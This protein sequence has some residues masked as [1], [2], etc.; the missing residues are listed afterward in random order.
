MEPRNPYAK[1]LQYQSSPST[2]KTTYGSSYQDLPTW[3]CSPTYER[4]REK[5]IPVHQIAHFPYDR[6]PYPMAR[7]FYPLMNK[8]PYQ[9][10]PFDDMQNQQRA[11]ARDERSRFE[12]A[13]LKRDMYKEPLPANRH[14]GK[15]DELERYEMPR[16][17][18]EHARHDEPR[19]EDQMEYRKSQYDDLV[20]EGHEHDDEDQK[21]ALCNK[22]FRKGVCM[23]R[24][25]CQHQ[26][27]D[28][29]TGTLHSSDSPFRDSVRMHF[30]C[31]ICKKWTAETKLV[32]TDPRGRR[33]M[34]FHDIGYFK[35]S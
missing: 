11:Q 7:D 4:F 21:S 34:K 26:Y 28:D 24:L 17:E 12:N 18:H 22:C 31:D 19:R 32:R 15:Y 27:C 3:E 9:P 29:C 2:F 16:M 23:N 25:G 20:A 30:C 6:S 33:L 1:S 14:G 5:E 35:T 10:V 8:K 13:T